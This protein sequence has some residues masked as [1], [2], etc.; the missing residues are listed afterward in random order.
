MSRSA[1]F[2]AAPSPKY[3]AKK[4]GISRLNSISDQVIE[5]G[6]MVVPGTPRDS[7]QSNDL[8]PSAA[9]PQDLCQNHNP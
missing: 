1:P 3:F 2:N 6:Q 9:A 5:I 8:S 4:K 7:L